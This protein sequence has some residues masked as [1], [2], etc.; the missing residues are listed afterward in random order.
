MDTGKSNSNMIHVGAASKIINNALGTYIQGATV[1]R[2]AKSIRDDLEANALFLSNHSES[3]LL[4]SCDLAGLLLEFVA[5]ARIGDVM[6]V[7][8]PCEL[9]CQFGIDIKR[10]SPTPYTAICSIADG[11]GGY[12]PTMSGV[13]GGGYS[14]E[15]IWWARLSPEG[16]YQI[17]DSAAKLM[18]QVMR[19]GESK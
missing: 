15:P 10:R 5:T 13:L 18:N 17:V 3:V 14:G 4:I 7:T 6:L 2:R 9:Y 16:G 19:Q 12:C 8:Q 1:N 11:Y